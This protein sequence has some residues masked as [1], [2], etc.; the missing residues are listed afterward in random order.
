M[1]HRKTPKGPFGVSVSL[2]ALKIF[3]LVR[4]SKGR[5][6]KGTHLPHPENRI[7]QSGNL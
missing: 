1:Q 7:N 2:E 5:T 6:R 3:S 4:N